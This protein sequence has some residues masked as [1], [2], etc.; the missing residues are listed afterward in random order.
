MAAI[1][2]AVALQ[3]GFAQLQYQVMNTVNNINQATIAVWKLDA[4]MQ[5]ISP[6]IDENVRGQEQFNKKI[7]EGVNS[8]SDL[9][10]KIEAAVESFESVQKL[11]KI[12]D[13]SD[14]MAATTAR[15]N[16]MNDGLQTTRELENMIYLSAE[17]TRGSYQ[18]TA[19][20]VS[21]FGFM[22][23]DAFNSS[24]EVVAFVEQINK[25]FA[26][27][28]TEA[29]GMDAAM[30]QLTQ[31][32]DSGVFQAE[33]YNSILAQAPNIIQTI[34]DYM[35]IPRERLRDMAAEGQI[36]ADM[37]KS[38][39]F[40][41]S[42]ETNARFEQMPWT[43]SQIWTTFQN[44][45]IKAFQPVLQGINNMANSAAFQS[46]VSGIITAMTVIADIIATLFHLVAA[47]GGFVADNWSII[48]PIVWGIAAALAVYNATMGIG[49]LITVRDAVAKAIHAKETAM[50][51]KETN[52]MAAAQNRLNAAL[53]KSPVTWIVIGIIAVTAALYAAVAAIN[54]L[55]GSTYSATGII[56][57]IFSVAIAHIINLFIT[58]WNIS[59]DVMAGLWNVFAAIANFIGNVFNDPVAAVIGLI[60]GMGDVILRVV[61]GALE[62]ISW[63]TFGTVDFT[64][65][66]ARV[67]ENMHAWFEESYGDRY[68]EYVETIDPD[69]LKMEMIDYED[70]WNAGYALGEDIERAVSGMNLFESGSSVP[71][72]GDYPGLQ[73]YEAGIAG[74]AEDT[75]AIRDAV[76]VTEE[77]LKYL[78]DIAE[79]EAVNRFTT[80]EIVIEQTNHN[81]LSGRLDLDGVVSGLTEAVNEAVEMIAEGVHV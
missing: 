76:D 41:A 7:C 66:I 36:S 31:V 14:R 13:L 17:H 4:V 21:K 75:G 5:N 27:A 34:A 70:A 29:A 67:R 53:L 26:I 61:E 51:K 58:L 9:G 72:L 30:Q 20:T 3:A 28:G 74:I 69:F 59:V 11:S 77:D 24:E 54:Q 80:A 56:C 16:L 45:A 25:Q 38:A 44:T 39:M 19:D 60:V 33:D 35:G 42:D 57:G 40:A 63:I 52:D 32:M 37:V 15:L 65:D 43:F 8:G 71:D 64:D 55:T 6:S 78:R 10:K 49:W 12:M 1:E 50:Q 48:E 47:V 18:A 2:T 62:A 79:Q 81:V 46:L 73:D 68:T 23:G 22:V